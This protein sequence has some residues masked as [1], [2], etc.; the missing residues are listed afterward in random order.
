M[1]KKPNL[2]AS[3]LGLVALLLIG[4]MLLANLLLRGARLDLTADKLYTITD[5]TEN[6]VRNLKEPVNLYFFFSEESAAELQPLRNHGVRVRELLEELVSRSD[7][8]LSLKVID[9]QPYTEEEDR[10]T[11]LGVSS[12]PIGA[13]GQRLYLG[14]AAT[15]S[16]DGKEAIPF[17]DPQSEEQL[18]YDIAKLIHNLAGAKKPVVA[19]LSSLSMTGDMDMQT[20]RPRP[21]WMVYQQVEQLYDVRTLEPTL[22]AIE[23]DVDVLVIVHPKDLPPAA[24]YAIDQYTLRGGR[25]LAF[26]DPDAQSDASASA[27]PSNPMAQFG[28][29]KSSSLDPLLGAWGVEFQRGQVVADLERGLVVSMRQGQQPSQ[30]IA[31]LG[32]DESSM[33]NDV[34]TGQLKSINL[35]TAGSLKPVEGSA[36]EHETLLHTSKQSGL[37]P[38]QRVNMA[39]DPAALRDGFKPTG[40]LTLAM[41]ISGTA[42]SAY[43][44]G[45]PAGVTAAPEALKESAKPINVIVVADTDLLLDYPW[46]QQQNF[47]GQMVYQPMADNGALV[48]NAVDNLGGS[49]DLISIRGRAAYRRPFE[50][51]EQIRREAE[52]QS[53]AKNQ[54]LQEQ[55]RQT[56][57]QL[58]KLQASQPPGADILSPEAAAA[59]ERFQQEKLNIRKE[60]RAIEANVDADIKSLG[61]VV[62]IVN[63]L[64]MPAII[65]GLGLLVALWRK[66]R[67][68]ALA[69]L[70]KGAA[71]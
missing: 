19:W 50:R 47:F 2:G 52:A 30:H 54:Q 60:L 53:R 34:I 8:K 5:G 3:G 42:K 61:F 37:I 41:R 68:H 40:E 17:L 38:V 10:A 6:I 66:R 21:P 9:P 64:L 56:E 27:D 14:L 15:N 46:L 62:K 22:T 48:W 36:L 58:G 28:A 55:L 33:S 69:M 26:L 29:D 4:V 59:I 31:V 18:E 57:E 65:V 23:P 32:L 49:A 24:L 70:R 39:M 45:P 67:R 16:T 13:L 7:G 35:L 44:D 25:V 63:L 51:V 43:P 12:T 11:E 71:A 20:G 1:F